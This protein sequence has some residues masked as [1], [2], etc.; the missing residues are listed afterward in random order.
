MLLTCRIAVPAHGCKLLKCGANEA[1][2][3]QR[4]SGSRLWSMIYNEYSR[5][6]D[7][8]YLLTLDNAGTQ[9]SGAY[10]NAPLCML[11]VVHLQRQTAAGMTLGKGLEAKCQIVC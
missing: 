6:L 7:S 3:G 5:G 11:C 2:I 10:Q 8:N 4:H 9:I 1:H